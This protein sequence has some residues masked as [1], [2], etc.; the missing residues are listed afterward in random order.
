MS[1]AWGRTRKGFVSAPR[2]LL[3]LAVAASLTACGTTTHYPTRLVKKALRGDHAALARLEHSARSGDAKAQVALGYVLSYGHPDRRQYAKAVYWWRKAVEGGSP[4]GEFNLGNAYYKGQGI[5]QDS[6]KAIYWWKKAI[7][8]WKKAAFGDAHAEFSLGNAY[9]EG[10]GVPKNDIKAVYWWKKA[11]AQGGRPGRYAALDLGDAYN[12]GHGVPKNATK[13]DYWWKKA[14]AQ[15]VGR[16]ELN[17]G[18][19][20][21]KGHGV[22]QDSVKAIYWLKKAATHRRASVREGARWA[23]QSIE[24]RNHEVTNWFTLVGA[25]HRYYCVNAK[26]LAA[27]K[28][29]S[30]Y[31]SPL[32][33]R[34][35]LHNQPSWKGIK[36]VTG[37]RG[38]VVIIRTKR[39]DQFF[40][41]SLA[42][43][44][45][46]RAMMIRNGFITNL[47]ALR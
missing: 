25:T 29:I 28:G 21:Y 16:A 40:F 9:S 8:K 2:W 35:F 24:Q 3:V 32:A 13:A 23:I 39:G 44:R 22:P 6:A 43:C 47:K 12:K 27:E 5:P 45:T 15:G 37:L 30:A 4:S 46:E 19:A 17:L 26:E 33:M 7:H 11:A 34:N 20:Y 10:H 18:N 38:K 42:L 36:V 1:K 41:S 14:A 31:A